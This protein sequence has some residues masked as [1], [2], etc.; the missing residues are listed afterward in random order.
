MWSGRHTQL[1]FFS[2]FQHPLVIILSLRHRQL[3]HIASAW[4]YPQF[5]VMEWLGTLDVQLNLNHSFAQKGKKHNYDYLVLET[6]WGE[7]CLASLSGFSNMTTLRYWKRLKRDWQT[8]LKW[9]WWKSKEFRSQHH[10]K[11]TIFTTHIAVISTI[12]MFWFI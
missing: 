3:N 8:R 6:H 12:P 5:V 1:A 2:P 7:F 10:V 9:L 4:I 11:T